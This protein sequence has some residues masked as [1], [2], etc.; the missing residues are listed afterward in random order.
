MPPEICHDA[1]QVGEIGSRAEEPPRRE[2][3]HGRS[4]LM[5]AEALIVAL[6]K[7]QENFNQLTWL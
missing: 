6:L 1:S 4:L 7:N 3:T 5:V 2:R